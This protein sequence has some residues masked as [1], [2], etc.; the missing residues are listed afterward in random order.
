[1]D[2]QLP[3]CPSA[4]RCASKKRGFAL[5]LGFTC[6]LKCTCQS[7]DLSLSLWP[8]APSISSISPSH[9]LGHP[10]RPFYTPPSQSPPPPPPTHTHSVLF[11]LHSP[12]TKSL[13]KVTKSSNLILPETLSNSVQCL[14]DESLSGTARST[15]ITYL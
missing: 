4:L 5:P 6:R 15:L 13:Y 11:S 2:L 10:S 9:S 1:M 7:A 3:R 8:L 12:S 14:W